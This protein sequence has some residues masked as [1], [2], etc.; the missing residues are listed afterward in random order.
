LFISGTASI[1]LDGKTLHES[2]V[3]AQIDT[4]V[5]VIKTILK[6]REMDWSDVNRAIAYFKKSADMSWFRRFCVKNNLS[7]PVVITQSAICRDDLLFEM[8]VDAIK[9]EKVGRT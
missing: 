8:E 7:L 3:E 4:T 2:N 9:G 5:Q 1:S 6:S